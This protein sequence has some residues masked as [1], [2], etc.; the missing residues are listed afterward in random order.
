MRGA[1]AFMVVSS[2]TANSKVSRPIL[3]DNDLMGLR[4]I[5]TIAAQVSEPEG[6]SR[7]SRDRATVRRGTKMICIVGASW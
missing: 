1:Q 3:L 5:P 2:S 4:T 6:R 7:T